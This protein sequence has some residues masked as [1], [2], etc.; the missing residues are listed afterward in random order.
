MKSLSQ[1]VVT[2]FEGTRLD[3]RIRGRLERLAPGGV[4]LFRRNVGDPA[5]LLRLTNELRGILGPRALIAVDQEGGRVARLRAPFTEWPAMRRVGELGDARLARGIGAA[6]GRELAAAG[7]NCDFAPV[8]DVDS[9]P[10]NPVIGDRAFAG[11]PAAVARL[12]LAFASGLEASGVVPCGKHFPGHG[13][14]AVDSHFSLPRVGRTLA[15]LSRVE[16]RPFRAAIR[17]GLPML[18][19]AHVVYEALDPVRPATLSAPILRG[20][21]RERLG[22]EGVVVSDDLAMHALDAAGSVAEIA[23][24]AVAAGCDLLLACQRLEDGERAV[25]ALREAHAGSRAWRRFASPALQRVRGLRARLAGL[26]RSHATLDEVFADPRR[27]RLRGRMR[28]SLGFPEG[29]T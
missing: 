24:G 11:E 28:A 7:F 26:P 12:A 13:D 20:L 2:G 5:A 9:N 16:L 18:M 8:L 27:A 4:V 6:I 23:V 25:A 3:A 17:R 19:T 10:S 21:L 15:E 14:T 1:L 22:F 29:E